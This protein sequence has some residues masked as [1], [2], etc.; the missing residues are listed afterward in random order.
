MERYTIRLNYDASITVDVLANDEG[1]ALAKARDKAEDADINQFVICN[2]RT[3]DILEK[4]D[5][6]E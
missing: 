6:R 1:E 5:E 3:S 2:E 4:A